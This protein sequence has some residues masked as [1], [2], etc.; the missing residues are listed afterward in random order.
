MRAGGQADRH[1]E[2][3]SRFSQL[4]ERPKNSTWYSRCIYVFCT[5]L[6]RNNFYIMYTIKFFFLN[7]RAGESF[8][9]DTHSSYTGV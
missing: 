5:N 7:N 4:C 8:L 9:P 1:V 3:N 2:A 6:K